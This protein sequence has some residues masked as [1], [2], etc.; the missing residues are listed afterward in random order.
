MAIKENVFPNLPRN[1]ETLDL[2]VGSFGFVCFVLLE[3]GLLIAPA[4]LVLTMDVGLA[5]V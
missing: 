4:G 1:R 5:L 3:T 2:A